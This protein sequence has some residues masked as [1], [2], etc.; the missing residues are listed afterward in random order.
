MC[1]KSQLL[2]SFFLSHYNFRLIGLHIRNYQKIFL[3]PFA[4]TVRVTQSENFQEL[5]SGNIENGNLKIYVSVIKSINNFLD[6]SVVAVLSAR[7]EEARF[8]MR[9][10]LGVILI[11]SLVYT[12]HIP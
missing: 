12:K 3:R 9:V 5:C 6:T 7:G 11:R 2:P 8:R 1:I 10:T 4:G